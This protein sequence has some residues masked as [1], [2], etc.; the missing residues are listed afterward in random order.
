MDRRSFLTGSVFAYTGITGC[1]GVSAPSS[2]RG[3][4][5]SSPATAT[6]RAIRSN[7]T[8][9]LNVVVL[10]G[11]GDPIP[12]ANVSVEMR[13]HDFYFGTA[14][15]AARLLR[16]TE[17]GDR[18]RSRLLDDFNTAVLENRHK[19]KQ[20]ETASERELADRATR[21]L[22]QNGFT[23]RGHTALWQSFDSGTIPE[24]VRAKF[25][26]DDPDRSEYLH[27]RTMGH[28]WDIV[29]HYNGQIAG[30][31]VLNEHLDY[32]RITDAIAPEHPPQEAP[33]LV[34]WFETA[35]EAAP[36]ADF[37]YNDYGILT[38]DE[39][40]RRELETLITY[41]QRFD[42]PIDGIGM[43]GHFG[44]PEQ[45]VDPDELRALLNRY[46][47]FGVDIL[48]TEYDT[49]GDGWTEQQ[50]ADHLSTLLETLYGH[51]ASVGFLMWGFWDGD[52]W[53]DNAPLFRKDWS[54]KPAYDVYTGLVFNE[55]WTDD[56][57]RT[58][59]SGF[60]STRAFLG[61]Y[62][63]TATGGGTSTTVTRSLTDPS[64]ETVLVQLT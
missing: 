59:E 53:R 38:G 51:P 8:A 15:D 28:V 41:L 22:L 30:W 52:H 46:A 24:D 44:Q 64:T 20:W 60:Y 48:I 56:S 39:E 14:V 42:A 25:Y 43:Q 26:S 2:D 54:E 50:E 45:A 16:E 40:R 31:D 10:D 21:W 19:W 12:N 9:E 4:G 32:Y 36:D 17:D 63:I 49:F 6:D 47:S 58:D 7:R 18:Y 27:D 61:H 33:P 34:G 62:E 29:H 37:Y 5:K 55:W 3:G 13:A 35:E 1:P 23:V 11:A 57:G